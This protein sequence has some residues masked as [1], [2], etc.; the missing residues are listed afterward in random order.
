MVA[1][2]VMLCTSHRLGAQDWADLG[3]NDWNWPSIGKVSYPKLVLDANGYPVVGCTDHGAGSV[4]RV[5][6]WDGTSWNALGSNGFFPSG[7]LLTGLVLDEVGNPVMAGSDATGRICVRRWNGSLWVPVGSDGFSSGEIA[8]VGLAKDANGTLVVAYIDEALDRHVVVKRWTGAVW[9]TIGEEDFSDTDATGFVLALDASGNPV[10]CYRTTTGVHL[11]RVQ[12][13]TGAVWETLPPI[14]L[15]AGIIY[16]LGTAVQADGQPIVILAHTVYGSR[17]TVVRWNGSEW[18]FVG[19]AGFSVG[20]IFNP[21]ISMDGE[22]K[23]VILYND[24]DDGGTSIRRWD[25]SAWQVL[26][27]MDPWLSPRDAVMALSPNGDIT[28]ACESWGLGMRALVQ[29]WN[30]SEWLDVGERGFSATGAYYPGLAMDTAQVVVAYTDM[31]L[32]NRTTVQRWNGS[33]WEVIGAAGIS[34]GSAGHQAVALDPMG[35]PVVAFADHANGGAT[36]MRWDG[37]TWAAIGPVGF[38]GAVPTGISMSLTASGQPVLALKFSIGFEDFYSIYVV[39]WDGTSWNA[40]GQ[41]PAGYGQHGMSMALD[42]DG[43]PVVGYDKATS[44]GSRVV[45]WDGT[46]WNILP[47]VPGAGWPFFQD[48]VVDTADKPILASNGTLYRWSGASW[49]RI[50]AGGDVDMDAV[51]L[52]IGAANEILV[53]GVVNGSS[54]VKRRVGG[55]WQ[56]LGSE[57]FATSF[58]DFNGP[59]WLATDRQGGV[60]VAYTNGGMFA[61]SIQYS[62]ATVVPATGILTIGPNPNPGDELWMS[63][64]GLPTETASLDAQL[65]DMS[66]RLILAKVLPVANGILKAALQLP[67]ALPSG[68]YVTSI[69]S[70]GSRWIAKVIVAKP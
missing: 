19:P 10:V 39:R 17:A 67:P 53:G 44:D 49:Q 4:F 40:V 25:G 45:R 29:R 58:S 35:F 5:R 3:P 16:G 46:E 65:H 68:L 32:G 18:E 1:L 62:T 23:P 7:S 13:W 43:Y 59:H 15:G 50:G 2:L 70:T 42:S 22:G 54:V 63:L 12:R 55:S 27:T 56:T 21:R 61:K 47:G 28:I 24:P 20:D 57:G 11:I 64:D 37:S 31:S 48:L 69:S 51:C 14:D 34:A 38:T 60:V 8:A 66:G 36:V 6:R 9:E 41:F 52:A 26:C 33:V 30:G